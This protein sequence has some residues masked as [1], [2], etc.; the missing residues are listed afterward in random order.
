MDDLAS[1][2]ALPG[3]EYPSLPWQEPLA[4]FRRT[5]TRDLKV[6]PRPSLGA[7]SYSSPIG[8]IEQEI[9]EGARF[10][11]ED[12]GA[13]SEAAE[14]PQVHRVAA[15]ARKRSSTGPR[16][17]PLTAFHSYP[18]NVMAGASSSSL[19]GLTS[20]EKYDGYKPRSQAG[21][22]AITT[23]TRIAAFPVV[24]DNF[25]DSAAGTVRMEAFVDRKEN[26]YGLG[27]GKNHRTKQGAPQ[28]DM[29]VW[30]V[31]APG[32]SSAR[33]KGEDPFTGF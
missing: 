22:A 9:V 31:D 4:G 13:E 25:S 29:N 12:G 21:S 28:K 6:K 33:V 26:E 18:N 27:R 30:G 2:P 32:A 3:Q 24:P 5:S 16:P 7:H 23:E 11:W 14:P 8:S 15:H 1:P 10:A 17:V 20:R 19:Q